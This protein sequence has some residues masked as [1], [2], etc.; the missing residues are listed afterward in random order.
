MGTATLG[1]VAS[2]RADTVL[3]AGGGITTI[4]PTLWYANFLTGVFPFIVDPISPLCRAHRCPLMTACDHAALPPVYTTSGQLAFPKRPHQPSAAQHRRSTCRAFRRI[5][6]PSPPATSRSRWRCMEWPR[7]FAMVTWGTIRRRSKQTFKDVVLNASYV[8]TAGVKLANIISPNSYTGA[9]PQ[10]APFTQFDSAG[11]VTGGYGHEYLMGTPSHST[12]HA[13]QVSASKNS[14]RLG[15]GFQT[16]YTFSKA[17]D[18]TS[19]IRGQYRRAFRNHYPGFSQD[20]W[21]PGADKG[22]NL[23]LSSITSRQRRSRFCPSTGWAFST[24]WGRKSPTAG[25]S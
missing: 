2:W 7:I 8:A 23:R 9:S 25:N 20:P 22:P 12:Y 24:R 16:S 15:L 21:N 4:L 19:A 3:R 10:F 6:P 13:L 18:D 17:L 11:Q 1:G 5:S 14:P